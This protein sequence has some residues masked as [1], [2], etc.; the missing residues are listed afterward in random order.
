MKNFL[1]GIGG[2]GA[3]CI[4]HLVHFCSAGLGPEQL[5][6][7]MV[8]QDDAN[9]NVAESRSNI[10]NYQRVRKILRTPGVSDIN[11]TTNLFKTNI[12]TV[13]GQT[14]WPPLKGSGSTKPT[15]KNIFKF[16]ALKDEI[17]DIMNCL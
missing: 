5:W 6:I 12:I 1:I 11:N 10:Q 15:L 7:G 2:S 17:Q 14:N 13:P 8:D 3:K 4:E 16:N 9:G